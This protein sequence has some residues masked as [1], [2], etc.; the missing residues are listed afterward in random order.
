[1]DVFLCYKFINELCGSRDP[2]ISN[3]KT[4]ITKLCGLKR[5]SEQ[6]CEHF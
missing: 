1:M 2:V 4:E 6:S 5:Y 3:S